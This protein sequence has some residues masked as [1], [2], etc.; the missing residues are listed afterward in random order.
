MKRYLLANLVCATD[1]FI[2]F[3]GAL[4]FATSLFRSSIEVWLQESSNPDHNKYFMTTNKCLL[5]HTTNKIVQTYPFGL[6]IFWRTN[7]SVST[8][9]N[10]LEI[11]ISMWNDPIRMIYNLSVITLRYIIPITMRLV[12]H[13]FDFHLILRHSKRVI[14]FNKHLWCSW[15]T[16]E[17]YVI[18]LIHI[19]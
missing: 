17:K 8:R 14:L 4:D 18:L 19:Y 9:S 15:V 13:H 12:K 7:W 6:L 11:L 3:W 5:M 16:D 1:T 2:S 10:C